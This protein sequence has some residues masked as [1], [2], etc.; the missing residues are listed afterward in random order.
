[1][2]RYLYTREA[3]PQGFRFPKSFLDFVAQ[4]PIADTRPW[5]LLCQSQQDADG[6]MLAVKRQYPTRKLVPFALWVGSDDVACFDGDGP[7]DD[8]IV[9]Y[10]HAYAS[11]GWEDRGHVANFEEWLKLAN[12]ES[13]GFQVQLEE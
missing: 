7:L 10:V 8:P 4:Q 5:W 1:M 11:P 13:T 2:K 6:W 9:H 3:L 12:R